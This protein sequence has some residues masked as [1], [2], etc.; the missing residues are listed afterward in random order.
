MSQPRPSRNSYVLDL[1]DPRVMLLRIRRTSGA[2]FTVRLNAYDREAASRRQWRIV[3][4]AT[5]NAIYVASGFGD[6]H[7]MLSHYLL[8]PQPHQIINYR[9]G[10]TLDCRRE[11]MLITDRSEL[12][13]RA[14][15]TRSKTGERYIH[16]RSD[17]ARYVVQVPDEKRGTWKVLGE[18]HT[19][20]G[21]IEA[22]NGW[23]AGER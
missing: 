13:S 22:R 4:S 10:D 3:T 7:V 21:A 19:L 17:R 16:R 18:T 2:I 23:L 9:S 6:A 1:D 11:N 5:H 12:S 8:E 20:A 15:P 14:L